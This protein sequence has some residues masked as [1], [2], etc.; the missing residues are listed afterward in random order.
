M[1]SL[2]DH[3]SL[4]LGKTKMLLEK[5]AKNQSWKPDNNQCYQKIEE[6]IE[7]VCA[8]TTKMDVVLDWLD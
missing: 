5:I 3:L 8:L 1:Q 2:E 7:E 4:T 6:I